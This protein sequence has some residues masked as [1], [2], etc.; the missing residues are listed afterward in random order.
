MAKKVEKGYEF[1]GF[2]L[3][4]KITHKEFGEIKII[5]FDEDTDENDLF[6]FVRLKGKKYNESTKAADSG[7]ITV[8]F[9][10]KKGYWIRG[11]K[12]DLE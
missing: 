7:Y 2:K 9:K 6:L 3:G 12:A 1:N 8:Y 10:N 5:G 4:Q 11:D